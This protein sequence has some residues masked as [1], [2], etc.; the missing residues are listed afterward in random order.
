MY[1]PCLSPIG[2]GQALTS[3]RRH[4][5][6]R[7]LP[8]Q[9]ADIPQ[10]VPKAK[11]FTPEGLSRISTPFGEL[12]ATLGDVFYVLLPRLPLTSVLF[13]NIASF[14]IATLRYFID[15]KD[16]VRSTCMPNPRRQ[17]SS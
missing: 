3:P 1:G 8:Y 6:G 5:L 10:T 17:R 11:N 14:C 13:Q 9:L 16:K 15:Q 12:F 2:G 7:L 4:S